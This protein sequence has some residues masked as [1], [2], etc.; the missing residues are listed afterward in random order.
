MV[1]EEGCQTGERVLVRVVSGVSRPDPTSDPFHAHPRPRDVHRSPR[2]AEAIS[3]TRD[4]SI[5]PSRRTVTSRAS[6][7]TDPH[8]TRTRR[9]VHLE[10][11][12]TP[13]AARGSTPTAS[14][15]ESF[16]RPGRASFSS[17][18]AG[19]ARAPGRDGSFPMRHTSTSST[20][21]D[22]R[23]TS[24]IRPSSRQISSPCRRAAGWW[25]TRSSAFP[26]SSTKCT[27]ISRIGDSTSPC[28]APARDSSR[29][30]ASTCSPAG[31]CTRRC[32]P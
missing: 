9:A 31:R 30:P 22:I 6:I 13:A 19:S 21:L 1:R 14:A 15:D 18:S 7:T 16:S 26:I 8:R 2:S 10:R 32:I 12:R 29:R 25:S 28:W 23:T 24:P 4:A 20:R 17:A 5:A 27:G 3:A 11:G